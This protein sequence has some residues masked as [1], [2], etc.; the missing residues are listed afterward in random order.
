[1][2]LSS[3]E[4]GRRVSAESASKYYQAGYFP[5]EPDG[6]YDSEPAEAYTDFGREVFESPTNYGAWRAAELRSEVGRRAQL[7]ADRALWSAAEPVPFE[8]TDGYAGSVESS[9]YK[10][11]ARLGG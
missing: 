10:A 2:H 4:V 6:V 9:A 11:D 7:R 8:E 5:E 3:R 1:M